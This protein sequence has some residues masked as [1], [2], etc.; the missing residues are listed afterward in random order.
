M[1]SDKNSHEYTKEM[2]VKKMCFDLK[3]TLFHNKQ[4]ECYVH[5]A[6]QRIRN[7]Y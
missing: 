7:K 5:S 4:E 6:I 3:M 2:N 1:L